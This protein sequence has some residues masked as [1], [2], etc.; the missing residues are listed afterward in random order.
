MRQ[1]VLWILLIISSFVIGSLYTK[2]TYLEKTSVPTAATQQ[3]STQ[4]PAQPTVTIDQV[5]EVF[6]KSLVKFG[7]DKKKLLLIEV[8]D[9]SC[10]YCHVAAGLNPELN[11]QVGDR[12]TLVSDGGTYV[13]PVPEMKKLIDSGNA[14]FAWLYTPGHG[15]GEMG[16][17]ALYCAFEKEKFWEV[18]DKI[19]TA[20]GYDFLN[21][22]VKNDKAKSGELSQFLASVF[23][24]TA[25]KTCLDSGKYDNR[26]TE[27]VALASGIGISGTPGFYINA[28]N[29]AGAY[30][31][32]D[33]ESATKP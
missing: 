7:D 5:K 24:P 25:M 28:I 29:F 3:P 18:H 16:T 30:S 19:M 11:K 27:D 15:N 23:D 10:P 8:A 2:V 9:P 13:A 1:T 32:K 26:L 31:W 12:F 22:S 17:K 6:N 20:E 14:S 33:M 4:Q 21:N